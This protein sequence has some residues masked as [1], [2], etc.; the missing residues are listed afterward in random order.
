MAMVKA[1]ISSLILAR[2]RKDEVDSTKEKE[3][4][5]KNKEEQIRTRMNTKK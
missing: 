2:N 3:I 4:K 5:R 1:R